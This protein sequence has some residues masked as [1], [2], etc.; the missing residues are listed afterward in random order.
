MKT[1]NKYSVIQAYKLDGDAPV[2]L[3]R[4][5]FKSG[6]A[7]VYLPHDVIQ[8]LNLS[9]NTKSLVAFL[10]DTGELNFVILTS[11]QSLVQML[12]PLVLERRR[13]GEEIMRQ[14]STELQTQQQA[15]VTTKD[16]EVIE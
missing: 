1:A 4:I 8:F 2:E 7:N 9:K 5:S 6:G 12:K 3:L 13:R 14:L 11:D 10:D 15:E 16:E